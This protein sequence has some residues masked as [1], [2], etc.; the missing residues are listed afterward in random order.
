MTK[1]CKTVD[2]RTRIKIKLTPAQDSHTIRPTICALNLPQAC[3]VCFLEP[4]F[5]RRLEA[6]SR[7]RWPFQCN[8]EAGHEANG[9]DSLS[10]SGKG[11]VSVFCAFVDHSEHPV[12]CNLAWG[13]SLPLS[14]ILA[15][16]WC[17]PRHPPP[18]TRVRGLVIQ[19][20]PRKKLSKRA[21]N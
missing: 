8:S 6:S 7:P 1:F 5:Y 14:S 20:N 21:G 12:A 15:P 16:D 2:V 19:L 9:L 18:S 3:W 11:E 4:Q 13:F 10:I 17:P